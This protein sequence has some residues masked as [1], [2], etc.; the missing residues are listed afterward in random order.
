MITLDE[1]LARLMRGVAEEIPK[2]G[3]KEKLLRSRAE[4]RPL[5]V[6][7]GVDPN[8]ADLHLGHTVPLRKLAVFQDLG[9]EVIFLIGDFTAQ[10]GDPT[11]RSAARPQLSRSEARTHART[12][13]AQ[14]KKVLNKKKMVVR[15]NSEWCGKMKFADVIR[16]TAKYTV[17]RL[18]ERDDFAKRYQ[19]GKP[20]GV[21]EFLY[22]LVQGYDSVVLKPDVELCSTDQIFNCHVAR[23][24]QEDAGQSPEVILAMPLI[25]GTDGVKK[26]SKSVPEHA[27][28]I[29]DPP[30]D[31]YGK[32]LSIPDALLHKY[33]RLLLDDPVPEGLSPRDTKHRLA[34][35]LVSRYH[36]AR[37]ASGAEAHFQRV[38]VEG[39][40]PEDAPVVRIAASELKDGRIWI[41]RLIVHARLAASKSEAQRFITQGA[42]DFNGTRL[43]DP[44]ADVPVYDGA[45]LKV[46]KRRF[47]RLK[48]SKD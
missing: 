23:V 6:K 46:G 24:L 37:A 9:H 25:E 32:I 42:V 17:A 48:V 45:V 13:L 10:I 3:L 27:I 11:D 29:T 20:I 18:L 15:Y 26:M 14:V 4:S 5:R 40:V 36:G 34:S 16:L 21:H 30:N 43:T 12:Y 47:A 31:M 7:F 19:T 8:T 22:P 28:G 2:G 44:T 35:Q 39:Q 33:W 38:V 41:V 1:E